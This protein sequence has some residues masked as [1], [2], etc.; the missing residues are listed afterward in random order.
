MAD[1]RPTGGALTGLVEEL[2]RRQG[3]T[4]DRLAE[5]AGMSEQ[6][7]QRL[8][9][10]PGNVDAGD[11]SMKALSRAL[12]VDA[13]LLERAASSRGENVDELVRIAEKLS[14]GTL[15]RLRSILGSAV[16]DGLDEAV[17]MA[18]QSVS[19]AKQLELAHLI[20][21][22]TKMDPVDREFLLALAARLLEGSTRD[23]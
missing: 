2:R 10:A 23:T 22:F 4:M 17:L 21:V 14:G 11:A 7:L 3:W 13:W 18:R 16:P 1:T 20:T 19:P 12:Q 6:A 9:D 15:S 5:A 8:M